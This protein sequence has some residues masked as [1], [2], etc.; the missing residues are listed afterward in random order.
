[1]P[2]PSFPCTTRPP[3]AS[4]LSTPSTFPLTPGALRVDGVDG[5]DTVDIG[6]RLQESFPCSRIKA[7][8]KAK[9][10]TALSR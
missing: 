4:T 5:V 8:T 7:V 10:L 2:Y 9:G 6:K 1:M 3:P